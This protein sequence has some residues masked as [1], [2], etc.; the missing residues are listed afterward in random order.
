ML[1]IKVPLPMI[2]GLDM[3]GEVAGLG[4]GVT[5][6]GEGEAALIN[7]IYPGKGLMGEMLDGGLAEYC[8]CS[9]DQLI[10]I[11]N[12]LSF[13]QAASLPVAHGTAHRMRFDNGGLKEGGAGTDPLRLRRGWHLLCLLSKARRSRIG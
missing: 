3:A 11:P 12:G 8:V 1:G 13:A 5:G 6:W 2:P 4:K 10:R 9:A 7:P